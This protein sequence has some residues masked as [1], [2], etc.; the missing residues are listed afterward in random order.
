MSDAII[1]QIRAHAR[2]RH[3]RPALTARNV[4]GL[5]DD[6][7]RHF[8]KNYPVMLDGA[9]PRSGDQCNLLR[10]ARESLA[11]GR[12]DGHRLASAII[13]EALE[14][15][16]TGDGLDDSAAVKAGFT[17]VG[18][19]TGRIWWDKSILDNLDD[20]LS[21]LD[22]PRAVLRFYD[23]TGVDPHSE[24]WNDSFDIDVQ[25]GSQGQTVNFWSGDKAYIVDL[26][27]IHA[28]GRFLR[29]A[30]TNLVHLPREGNGAADKGNNAR[31]LLKP[32]Q[33]R[34]DPEIKPDGAARNW[35]AQRPDHEERD[36][37][38]ELVVHMVYRSFLREGSRALRRAPKLFRRDPE[39]LRKEFSQ[40]QRAR[41]RMVSTG[42]SQTAAPV[43]LAARLDGGV[44]A[45]GT[46]AGRETYLPALLEDCG[47]RRMNGQVDAGRFF[48]YGSLLREARKIG[49]TQTLPGVSGSPVVRV[50]T[51]SE[52]EDSGGLELVEVMDGVNGAVAFMSG[53]AASSVFEA[54]RNLRDDVVEKAAA[55]DLSRDLSETANENDDPAPGEKHGGDVMGTFVARRHESESGGEE[56]VRLFGGAEAKRMAKAGVR[57]TRMALTLEGKMRPGARLK[58][59]G[60]LVRADADGCFRLECVLSGKRASIP[61]R[62]GASIGGEARSLISVEWEKRA[63]REKKKVW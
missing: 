5:T 31:T 37:D 20:V 58:V 8:Q 48:W 54:A 26:G 40:R 41:E 56:P 18:P 3:S 14:T 7:K 51:E 49:M 45:A 17:A 2:D 24:R 33:K 60:K 43:V 30:R 52:N 42:F 4:R 13:R 44:A 12:A 19:K 32:G 15:V 1:E 21:R 63:S 22:R 50:E 27:Y 61:M 11:R 38:T 9:L 28:D 29:L 53:Q 55:F 6:I 16:R 34:I 36:M 35:I 57:I 46:S 47:A 39:A 25:I 59:A 62:A 10:Q 23:V